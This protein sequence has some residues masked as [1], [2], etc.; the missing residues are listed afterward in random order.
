MTSLTSFFMFNTQDALQI[1]RKIYAAGYPP[2][3]NQ[4]SAVT[5]PD[6]EALDQLLIKPSCSRDEFSG[7]LDGCG[8][9]VQTV[10]DEAVPATI[11]QRDVLAVIHSSIAYIYRQR[12]NRKEAVSSLVIAQEIASGH[13]AKARSF[14]ELALLY[15]FLEP[16]DL[17]I[18]VVYGIG[19]LNGYKACRSGVKSARI[20]GILGSC[21]M[22]RNNPGD[23]D[24]AEPCFKTDLDYQLLHGDDYGKA[25]AHH[26]MGKLH[27]A[28]EDHEEALNEFDISIGLYKKNGFKRE[29]INLLVYKAW[30]MSHINP[31]DTIGLLEEINGSKA[32]SHEGDRRIMEGVIQKIFEQLSPNPITE[33]LFPEL[34]AHYM[35]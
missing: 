20:R 13:F 1:I 21:Y 35:G 29:T 4:D 14:E 33:Q 10:Q 22:E 30:A 18:A 24:F 23:T 6:F 28:R 11:L 19:S 17:N 25:N 2:E 27:M 9:L 34:M 7:I 26:N 8:E 31:V 15:R 16:R 12:G 32:D 3:Y 5:T